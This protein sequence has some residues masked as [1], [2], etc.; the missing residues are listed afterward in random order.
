MTADMA[1]QAFPEN[2]RGGVPAGTEEDT[3]VPGAETLDDDYEPS[4]GDGG[5]PAAAGRWAR[6]LDAHPLLRRVTG[7]SAGSIIAAIT[8]EAAFAGAYGWLHSGT[9]L[10]SAAGFFGGAVPNYILNRRWAWG[11]DRRGRS[12]RAELLL[13]FGISL[14]SFAVSAVTTNW[15]EG[16]ARALTSSQDWQVVLVALAFLAVSA[17]FF[18][19]KFVAYEVI[20]FTK[21]SSAG[22]AGAEAAGAERAG[23]ASPASADHRS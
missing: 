2:S 20:V 17:V 6:L 3:F 18:I 9:T 10:A 13:Y 15:A 21:G 7:Y 19:G 4:Q 8:S 22:S 1:D 12:P 5:S 23:E 16:R 14:A 11:E